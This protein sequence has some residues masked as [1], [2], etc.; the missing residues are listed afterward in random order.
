LEHR[1]LQF[2]KPTIA[3]ELRLLKPKVGRSVALTHL[4]FE[5]VKPKVGLSVAP[6]YIVLEL[7][8]P[9]RSSLEVA[10]QGLVVS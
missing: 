1:T 6:T 2:Q 7:G 4:Y 9:G 10:I 3:V 8:C 5:L